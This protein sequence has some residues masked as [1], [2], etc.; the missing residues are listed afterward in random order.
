M[1]LRLLLTAK[2]DSRLDRFM[3]QQGNP[4]HAINPIFACKNLKTRRM[5]RDGLLY[6]MTKHSSKYYNLIC[7]LP[8]TLLQLMRAIT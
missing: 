4:C 2:D 3:A 7:L 1:A 5:I 6:L 8:N